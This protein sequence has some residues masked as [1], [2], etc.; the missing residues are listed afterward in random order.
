MIKN[1]DNLKKCQII[2]KNQEQV[3]NCLNYLER[4]GFD[5]EDFTDYYDGCNIIFWRECSE[6][7]VFSDILKGNSKIEFYNKKLIKTI[8]KFL[9]EKQE[10]KEDFEVAKDGRIIKV[11]NWMS[12]KQIFLLFIMNF[13]N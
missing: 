1:I 10:K 11:N 2:C 7:F 4:L 13:M 9:K 8:Q 5:V 12:E 6:K 3:K